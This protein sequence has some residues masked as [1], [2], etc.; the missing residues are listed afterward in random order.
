VDSVR[1]SARKT[2]DICIVSQ[3]FIQK[4]VDTNLNVARAALKQAGGIQPTAK[5]IQWR[6][7][8]QYTRAVT[9]FTLPTWSVGGQL[10]E[11]DRSF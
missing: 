1:D 4:S 9:P 7:V 2:Y 5:P 3:E 11:G 10:L 8:N 6:A